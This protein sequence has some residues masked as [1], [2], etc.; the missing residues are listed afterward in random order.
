MYG[1]WIW[2]KEE[3]ICGIVV[4]NPPAASFY[5]LAAASIITIPSIPGFNWGWHA[6]WLDMMQMLLWYFFIF[7]ANNPTKRPKRNLKN[8]NNKAGFKLALL[9][10]K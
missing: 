7:F 10:N 2:M 4:V 1:A 5:T 9:N 3:K 6:E 8:S